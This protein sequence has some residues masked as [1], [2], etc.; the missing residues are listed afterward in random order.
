MKKPIHYLDLMSCVTYKPC[1]KIVNIY[2]YYRYAHYLET[3]ILGV[4]T[5]FDFYIN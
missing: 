3:Y 1:M 4:A 2:S 5:G